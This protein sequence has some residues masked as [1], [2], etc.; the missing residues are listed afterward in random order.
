MPSAA[1]IDRFEQAG[2]AACLLEEL[3][4][5]AVARKRDDEVS[6]ELWR[7][8]GSDRRL[9]KYVINE[10]FDSAQALVDHCVAQFGDV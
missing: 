6:L 5:V 10:P 4:F 8:V 9:M 3:G 2:E 7:L 1:H